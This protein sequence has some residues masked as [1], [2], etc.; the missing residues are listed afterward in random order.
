LSSDRLLGRINEHQM[1]G[2]QDQVPGIQKVVFKDLL[3]GG[4][5]TNVRVEIQRCQIQLA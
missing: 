5:T 3:T 2:P 4:C 1:L